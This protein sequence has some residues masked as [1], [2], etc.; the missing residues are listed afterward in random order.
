MRPPHHRGDH[1]ARGSGAEPPG[2]RPE[3]DRD[4]GRRQRRARTSGRPGDNDGDDGN[5]GRGGAR[6][7]E[8]AEA[9]AAGT[10]LDADG[11]HGLPDEAPPPAPCRTDDAAARD[12]RPAW[13]LRLPDGTTPAEPRPAD[14]PTTLLLLVGTLG[15]ALYRDRD[16]IDHDRPQY[17]RS[18]APGQ[19]CLL[20][21][22]A[23]TRLTGFPD[24]AQL[25]TTHALVPGS[26]PLTPDAY[27]AAA[28][29]ARARL[30]E[31]RPA[32]AART[33]ETR[34]E[35]IPDLRAADLPRIHAQ[36]GVLRRLAADRVRLS[37]LVTTTVLAPERYE[38]SRN[39]L[40]LDRLVLSAADGLG[41]EIR[42]NTN[43]RPGNQLLPTTTPT[44]SPPGS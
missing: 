6:A 1:R 4:R 18:L 41:Y 26:A 22:G 31:P 24:S 2:H 12:G 44:R 10:D 15:L 25:I 34:L 8:L 5:D 29:D 17:L 39:T 28:V 37:Y 32:G 43:P 19:T 23:T 33:A 40:L 27:R 30:T 20:H 16:D 42:L 21:S 38:A 14:R 9:T 13:Y 36:S 7:P 3:C 35:D 11:G